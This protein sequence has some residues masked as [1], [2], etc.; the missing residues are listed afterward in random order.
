MVPSD[1]MSWYPEKLGG[2][3]GEW[4]C[5]LGGSHL[6][7]AHTTDDHEERSHDAHTTDDHEELSHEGWSH[8]TTT[9]IDKNKCYSM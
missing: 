9:I 1:F 3:H 2:L 6:T 4:S 7:D 5:D 8:T